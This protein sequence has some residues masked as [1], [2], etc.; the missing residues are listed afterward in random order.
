MPD[1]LKIAY[2]LLSFPNLTE[3]FILR[4][5]LTLR[6]MGYDVQVFAIM[7]PPKK[8]VLHPQVEQMQPYVHYSPYFL[9]LGLVLANLY[10]I[11]R[12]PGRYF[13]ALWQAI[14][15][16]AP[17]LEDLAKTLLIFPKTVYF[18]RQAQKMGV[19]VIHA[20][21]V[22]TNGVAAQIA[23][24]LLGVPFSLTA[25]AYDIFLRKPEAVRRQLTLPDALATISE[26]HR[27]Y[28]ANLCPQ[29]WTPETVDLVH[30]GLDP[31]EFVP[32]PQP[33]G[34]GKAR[35][36]AVGS[37]AEKKGHEYLI[38]AAALLAR[39]GCDFEVSIIG[40]GPLRESLQARIDSH[41]LGMRVKLLGGLN[42]TQVKERY[43]QSDIFTLACVTAKNGDKDGIPVAIM[44]AMA[45]EI[46]AVSTDVAGIP[47]LI[48]DGET[49]LLAPEKDAP[50]LAAALNRLMNEPDLRHRLSLQG[51]RKILD[52]FDIQQTAERMAAIFERIYRRAKS[53]GYSKSES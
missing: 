16:T 2:F 3:T 48:I 31:S 43:R 11:F 30:C 9:S 10:Y 7:P 14:W 8:P 1:R 51:R 45:T 27:R 49:G 17:D 12:S 41:G 20:H 35:I 32:N 46:P 33:V 15:Q 40:Q 44:E 29:R 22:A 47:E 25:H 42:Q 24:R 38:D 36:V 18:A 23:A 5:M 53:G 26:Y 34:D 39:D 52:E 28:V 13:G 4:E 50:A 6:A 37:L 21:F 19:D